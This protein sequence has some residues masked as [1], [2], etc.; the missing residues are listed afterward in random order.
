MSAQ[1]KFKKSFS[2]HCT[3]NIETRSHSRSLI[4]VVF[5]ALLAIFSVMESNNVQ[6]GSIV[7]NQCYGDFS[8]SIQFD[9]ADTICADGDLDTF[10]SL[11]FFGDAYI[12]PNQVWSGGE[13]LTD[14]RSENRITSGI[15]GGGFLGVPIGLPGGTPRGE[16]DLILDDGAN[17]IYDFGDSIIG[18]GTG[19]AFRVVESGRPI[20]DVSGI[21]SRAAGLETHYGAAAK[22]WV[23]LLDLADAAALASAVAGGPLGLLEYA[24]WKPYNDM[25]GAFAR[26]LMGGYGP[27]PT[28][29]PERLAFGIL[30]NAAKKWGDLARDPP[31]P[32]F[33]EMVSMD[34][35]AVAGEVAGFIGPYT[36]PYAPLGT[37]VPE[38]NMIAWAR[39]GV[40]QAALVVAVRETIEKYQGADQAFDDTFAYIQVRQLKEYAQLLESNMADSIVAAQAVKI[41]L[42][43]S[44]E[45]E[46]QDV[47][48]LAAFQARVIATGLTAEE[49]SAILDLG[50][51][52]ADIAEIVLR[53]TAWDLPAVDGTV[54]G[55]IDILVAEMTAAITTMQELATTSQDLMDFLIAKGV[56]VEHPTAD[57]GGPYAGVEGT[58]VVFDASGSTDPQSEAMTY[59]WDFDGDGVFDDG[60]G[61]GPSYTWPS[62]FNGIIGLE[63]TDASGNVDI[64]YADV[65]IGSANGSPV[66]TDFQP[67]STTLTA[68]DSS[69]LSFSVTATDPDSDPL[70]YE[71]FVEGV[72][73]S[74][75]TGFT[76]TPLITDSGSWLVRVV[77]SDGSSFS[78]DVQETRRV[79]IYSDGDGD[80][81]YSDTDCDDGNS[82]VNPG[83]TEIA[84]N[85][86]DDDCD[87]GTP[88]DTDIDNDGFD[89]TVDCDD[90][91]SSVFPGATEVCDSV[92]N[93]CD[94]SIDE[95]F[96]VDG[97][98]VTVCAGDC[99]DADA[100]NFPGNVEVCDG[101]DNTCEGAVDE[102]FDVDGDGVTVCAGDCDDADAN[103]FPGNVEVCDGA[104]NT[105][106]GFIDD[107]FDVDG[108]GVTVCAGDCDDA[109]PNNF[110]GNVESCDGADNTCDSVIDEGVSDDVD[111]DGVSICAGDCDDSDPA[112]FPG[113]TE[114]CD[115]QDN[116][117]D[118]A[119]DEGFDADGDGISICAAPVAD[120]DDS[121]AGA[122]PGRPELFHNGIDDDCDASTLD[123]YADTFIIIPDDAGRINYASSNGDGTWA[124]FRQ[125]AQL[126]GAIRGATIADYDNDGV[127]DFLVGSPSGNTTT[128]YLFINDGS[129]NFTNMGSVGTGSNANSYQMDM[130]AGDFNHDGNMD[131]LG[132]TNHRF[133]H[134][135]LGDGKGNFTVTTIDLGVGNGRGLDMAD[136]NHDGYLDYARVTYSSGQIILYLG[137]GTGDFVSAGV[138][139]DSGTDPYGLTAA[140][141]NNDGNVDVLANEGGSGNPTFFAGNG[142]GTFVAGVPVPSVDFNNHGAYDNYDFNR[143]GNQDLVASSYSSRIVRYYPGNGD[144]T[145]GAEVRVN[146]SNTAGNIFGISAPPGPPPIGD[147]VAFISPNPVIDSLGATVDFSGEFSTDDGAIASYEWDFDDGATDTGELASHSF[148]SLE[149]DYSVQLAVTD[150]DGNV[151]IGTGLVRLLGDAP[152]AD[153]GGPYTFGEAFATAGAY[154][155]PIDGSASSDDGA[156]ALKFAWDLGNGIN[157]TFSSGVISSGLWATAGGAVVSGGEAVVTGTGGWGVRHLVSKPQYPRVAGDSYRG[158]LTLKSGGARV[159]M[160][161][162]K[163]TN[164][165]Y[166]YTQFYYA[167]YFVNGAIH[168]YEGGAS[169]GN[170][171][172]GFSD[173]VSY[174]LRIDVKPIGATYYMRQTGAPTWTQLY[175]SSYSSA[176]PLRLGVTLNS[177]TIVQMDDLVAP[178]VRSTLEQP[179]AN[180][181][182]QGLYNISL[183]VT[184][185]VEQTDSDATTV[186]LIAGDPPVADAGGPYTPG[187]AQA[188]CNAWTVVFDGT[189]SSDDTAIY[190]YSWDFGDGTFGSGATPSHTYAA[191]GSYTVLLTVTD[192]ALQTHTAVATVVTTPGASPIADPAGPYS[193]DESAASSGL[194]TVS[195]DGSGSTD[196]NGLCDFVW[197]FGDGTTGTGITPSHQY[198]AA[199]SYTVS[200]TVRD[201]AHQSHTASTTLEVTV[202]DPPVTDDGGPYAIDEGQAQA[203]QWTASFD[204]SASTDDFGIWTYSWD[205][206]DGTMGTGVTPI[207]VYSAPGTYDV[208]LTVTDNGQQSATTTTQIT[209]GGNNPPVADAGP[210]RT[211]EVGQPTTLDAS[212]STDDN[213][214]FKYQWDFNLPPFSETFSG[215]S[216][217]PSKWASTGAVLTS[218]EAIVTG[219]GGWSNRYLLT[220]DTFIRNDGDSYE[221]RL[222][223]ESGGNRYVMWGL[224]NTNT[225]YHYGQFYYAIYFNNGS[226]NI[227]EGG[228]HRGAVGSFNDGTSYDVR[229]DVKATGATYYVRET[230]AGSWTQLYDS[231]YSSASEFR[232][233]ATVHSG[234]IHMDDFS[235]PGPGGSGASYPVTQA[236]YEAPG[237]YQ[238]SV[239][240]TDHALQTDT[241][242]T[243]V[244]VILGNPPTADAGGPYS[245]NEMIPTRLNARASSDD[246]GIEFYSWDFGD[247][248]S[249]VTRNPFVDHVYDTEGTYTAT[250]TVT[251]FAGQSDSQNATVIVSPDPAVAAVP[252]AFS[253]GIEIPH[254]TWSGK[255]ITLK[256][257][258]WTKR[259]P[260]SYTWDF[261]DGSAPV[262]G[263]TSN[264]YIDIQTKHTYNG[265]EGAPFIA[266]VTVTDADG[267]TGSDQYL[268]RIRAQS[269]DIE[270][271]IAID[272][273][274]WYLHRQQLRSTS[275]GALFGSWQYSSYINHITGSSVQ[276]FEINGHQ[277][278]GDVRKDPYVETVG[279]G[280]NTL[281]SRLNT[282]AISAQT[283]GNPDSNANGIGLTVNGGRPIY[284]GGMV[285]DGIAS[286]NSPTVFA[287]AGSGDVRHRTY[288]DILQDMIDQ[289]SWGQYDHA[290]VGGGWRYSWNQHP[291]NS[292]AQWPAIGVLAAR[293]TFGIDFPQW[294]MDEND[295]WLTYSY[296]G[297]GFGYTGQG[298]GQAQTPSGMIQLAM[299]S[300]DRDD[301]RWVTAET[302]ISNNWNSWYSNA[303]TTR[304]R[305]YYALF[306]LTKTMRVA[307]PSPVINLRGGSNDGLDWFKHP[308][309]GVAST[310]VED[311]FASSDGSFS[312]SGSW[313]NQP[314]RSAWGVIMLSQSLFVQ[315]PVADAGSD[316]VWGVDAP[317]TLDGSGSFHLDP[318]RDIVTYEWDLDG[319]GV[320]DTTGTSPTAVHTWSTV[321]YPEATLPR[322]IT[323]TLRVTDNNDPTISDTDTV[324]I[325]IAIP[326][327]PPIA[328][329]NGPYNCTLGLPCVLDGSGS[330]DIDP[331]DFIT[332]WEWDL[333]G[334]FVYDDATG[335]NPSVTFTQPGSFNVGLRVVDNA[336]LNDLD[337]DDVQDPE[338]RLDDFDFTRVT[339]TENTA[340]V[341]DAGGPYVVDEGSSITLDASASSDPDFNPLTY[342]WDLD[343]DGAYDNAT[344]LTTNFAALDD[345]TYTVGLR[346]SDGLLEDT[347]TVDVI[348][349]NV[350][351]AVDAGPDQS[352]SEGAT[353]NLAP[354]T[355][356]DPGTQDTH[357]ATIDWGDGSASDAGVVSETNGSGSVAGSHVY[358]DNGS[359]TVTVTVT[360]D[361]SGV[362]SDTLLVTVGNL[363][364][365]V[366]AGPDASILEGDA[367]TLDPATF[368]DA[369]DLDT[370]TASID[371]GDTHSEVG[372]VSEA[373]GNG[374]VAGSHS[375]PNAGNYTVTVTVMDNDGDSGNDTFRVQVGSGNVAPVADAGGPYSVD[376]GSSTTL[377]GS[378]SS[379]ANTD[380]LTLTWDLDNDGAYDDATGLTANFD[381]VD[382]GVYQVGLKVS[383]G[384]LSDTI[385]TQVTVNNV[386]PVVTAGA[387]ATIGEGDSFSLAPAGFTDV[388]VLDTHTASINWG[389]G[390]SPQAGAV[391][392]AGGNGSVNGSHSY[393]AAGSYTVTV[394]V[395]DDDGGIGSDT[396]TVIVEATQVPP[397]QTIFD[398]SGR[399]KD[400]KVGLSWTL[401]SGADA[402]NVYRSTTPG[403]PHTLV[404]AG[405]VTDYGVYEDLGLVN[406]TTYYYVV[407]SLSNGKE[408]LNSN[409]A[410]ATPNV[411][412]RSR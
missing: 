223:T 202:N 282:Q 74:T 24:I 31:D 271:N 5:S 172:I 193:V 98:G 68:T 152:T 99:D 23:N 273:G 407:T 133:I 44:G 220:Q 341:A 183:A 222:Q 240:V 69:P 378:G 408:S 112:N 135:G 184:D 16:Y 381:G 36:Y 214:I 120:C 376:E 96:D 391:I 15:G 321:D 65:T 128:F 319:D 57:A 294:V 375:Y 349:N 123:D 384:F 318:F 386:A 361:D 353:V 88:D 285:M 255:E 300:S 287:D 168:I 225:N 226:I 161:G 374:S 316:R 292:A 244:T 251:D 87:A 307:V 153:A 121:N 344:G 243:V 342:E 102:G 19:F 363:P 162:L 356:T 347:T 286:S 192:H 241:D 298:A 130:T 1:L 352:A 205:F 394:T 236:V 301:P 189:G 27:N 201:H 383:D 295:R 365:V 235:A 404:V 53:I 178:A 218:G 311:S 304:F 139:G 86:I 217:D 281:F 340:P 392:E 380:P 324:V 200:L 283:A 180:Y 197:D 179:T 333:D 165:N 41:D 39:L 191:P 245:T 170:T 140:D 198:S 309:R 124:D 329:A 181:S 253:G 138:I 171:G 325:T 373:G 358:A 272:N 154:S 80:G 122:Y 354:A 350:A 280:L 284:E 111:G 261:G 144:G 314:T 29:P 208:E 264:P 265:V 320:F 11:Q 22:L 146:P 246:F 132:N 35:V 148:P 149:S 260:I 275:G 310:L 90:T 26:K 167:I 345:G 95:G 147:P 256:A 182:Q 302:L 115:D 312:G 248:Q 323:V 46:M 126:S 299:N 327:H 77:I 81:F 355:F 13:T 306:A 343:N 174:D 258:A 254:D 105:C 17:G 266:T 61:I 410:S 78:V 250:L 160:W 9:V 30:G 20:P 108:D 210:S 401:V 83:A 269:Q 100:N 199:G 71:W 84:N 25:T 3:E 76:L 92:D 289:Y 338:E 116:N 212:A 164:T 2:V 278:L 60:V 145:F 159:L 211:N 238:P 110:P 186:N 196:D 372:V 40:Q 259:T 6:A 400:S 93:N 328:D 155:V 56:V 91:D 89:F 156:A 233:G 331:T 85:G 296:N 290:T 334:D 263:T 396:L 230:G 157:E 73:V 142:D 267:N 34:S 173:D 52:G 330:F 398:L 393:A 4:A 70:S 359:Y 8:H 72:S 104:D 12:I 127:L 370:H 113:N 368:T 229:I 106:N 38:A 379:D 131:F 28:P 412:T 247:G 232:L 10:Q 129:D 308:T 194:W 322:N 276:A 227:Y 187:E 337:G 216:I 150:D 177:T 42:I 326:P 270:I 366:E 118:S 51:T 297:S 188:S 367:V 50:F 119:I 277:Q 364:P 14:I 54:A 49:E 335:E 382:D 221:G 406:G 228:T 114:I 336:V 103:N 134:R 268:V 141:F 371:W 55:Q 362:G 389:D 388:G 94:G 63:V 204:A 213:G 409:E 185:G 62:E 242:S 385:S 274:L 288:H 207:H 315:P 262:T 249:F 47:S 203:G 64:D 313:V 348:V 402:Y 18:A 209:V 32:L 357:T 237:T 206:G 125:I 224:K 317:L 43:A 67:V 411:R 360:D 82:A 37:G 143:D 7:A 169:R 190:Q 279:R 234:I 45:D 117:C 166:S 219:A 215:A 137:D 377:D 75:A 79:N 303:A 97:D 107:G 346:V 252:W 293:Q 257:V 175:D 33:T 59:A 195:F 405:H 158:R 239:T 351:P 136:F 66:I 305:N 21:K 291:D 369:G 395:T 332:S 58:A 390:S 151:G 101:V 387:G 231:S 399:P 163:N 176:S 403:G 48:A 397:E 339:V 109:D